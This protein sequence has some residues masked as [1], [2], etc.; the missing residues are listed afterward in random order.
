MQTKVRDVKYCRETL[1]LA[2]LGTDGTLNLWDPNL[3]CLLSVSASQ[4]A[5]SNHTVAIPPYSALSGGRNAAYYGC[6]H[7]FHRQGFQELWRGVCIAA[8]SMPSHLSSE[9]AAP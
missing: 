4:W 7:T 9:P 2:T 5:I 1:K 8:C 6:G 3:T